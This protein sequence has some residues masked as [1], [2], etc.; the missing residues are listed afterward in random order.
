M[1]VGNSTIDPRFGYRTSSENLRRFSMVII[2][3]LNA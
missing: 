2:I 3:G 1:I